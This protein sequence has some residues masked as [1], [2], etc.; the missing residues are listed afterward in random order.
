MHLT[1]L[2]DTKLAFELRHARALLDL[3]MDADANVVINTLRIIANVAESP[4]VRKMLKDK[5]MD[6][7]GRVIRDGGAGRSLAGGETR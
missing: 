7:I 6:T 2:K 1:V 4:I 3:L 5:G